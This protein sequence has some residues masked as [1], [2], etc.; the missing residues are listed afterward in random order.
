MDGGEKVLNKQEVFKKNTDYFTAKQKTA[1]DVFKF[2]QVN[3]NVGECKCRYW[4]LHA[5]FMIDIVRYYLRSFK[6]A[7]RQD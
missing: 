6:D 2:R 5:I 3:Q 1:Y 4:Q 7:H